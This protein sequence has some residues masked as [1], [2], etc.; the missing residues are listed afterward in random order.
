MFD[1]T[2]KGGYHIQCGQSIVDDQDPFI[3]FIFKVAEHS[4]L[5][6]LRYSQ[7]TGSWAAKI[8]KMQVH[9]KQI[10]F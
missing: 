3:I 6:P 10:I 2:K 8:G 1:G 7:T 5:V 4:F 9:L